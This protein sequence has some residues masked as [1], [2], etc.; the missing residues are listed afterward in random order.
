M[1]LTGVPPP[2]PYCLMMTKTQI[3]IVQDK[4]SLF[5]GLSTNQSNV[6]NLLG[7]LPGRTSNGQ[8]SSHDL[9]STH[10]LLDRG[11][12]SVANE[13]SETSSRSN[14]WTILFLCD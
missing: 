13:A 9:M 6:H 3:A 10:S 14:H 5:S 4:W 2:P 11:P 12:G 8:P 1:S 7:N